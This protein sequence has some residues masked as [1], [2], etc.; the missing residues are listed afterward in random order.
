MTLPK[1]MGSRPLLAN[2]SLRKE[3]VYFIFLNDNRFDK[4]H[5]QYQAVCCKLMHGLNIEDFKSKPPDCTCTSSPFIY[6]MSG[7][8]LT[9]GL[10]S[11]NDTTLRDMM[12][13][14][15]SLDILSIHI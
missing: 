15:R 14:N 13:S 9:G 6:N 4:T 8:V 3:R 7:H 11:I 2:E 5:R 10:N 12:Y 1:L